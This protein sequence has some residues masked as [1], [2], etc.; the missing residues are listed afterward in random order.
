MSLAVFIDDSAPFVPLSAYSDDGPSRI[1]EGKQSAPV[2]RQTGDRL[3]VLGVVFVGEH[4]DRRFVR[5]G[6]RRAW[7]RLPLAKRSPDSQR[8]IHLGSARGVGLNYDRPAA[9]SRKPPAKNG[10]WAVLT[11][12]LRNKTRPHERAELDRSCIIYFFLASGWRKIAVE[13]QPWLK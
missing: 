13:D 5:H 10:G 3:V 8:T 1:R 11:K 12:D 6:G 9:A 7:G 4:V 2:L